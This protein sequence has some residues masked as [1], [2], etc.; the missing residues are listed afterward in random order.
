[1]SNDPALD[2][3][4]ALIP[5]LHNHRFDEAALVRYLSDRIPGFD[6]GCTVHQFQGGQSN[7]TFHLQTPEGAAYVLRKKPGGKLLPSAHAVDR[8]AEF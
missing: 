3:G 5:V 2:A 6:R 8:E 4:P 1:M 7:P